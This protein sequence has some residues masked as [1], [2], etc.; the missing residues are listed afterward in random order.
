MCKIINILKMCKLQISAK[1]QGYLGRWKDYLDQLHFTQLNIFLRPTPACFLLYHICTLDT[2]SI[3]LP[4]QHWRPAWRLTVPAQG[5]V[6]RLTAILLLTQE[7]SLS[8]GFLIF[9]SGTLFTGFCFWSCDWFSSHVQVMLNVLLNY[10]F[11]TWFS[12]VPIA[13]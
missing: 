13:L 7:L 1:C 10:F 12:L 2:V 11:T 9:Y 8:W 6:V 3:R 5:V 4:N